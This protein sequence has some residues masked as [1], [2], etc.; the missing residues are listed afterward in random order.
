M[1][2][3]TIWTPKVLKEILQKQQYLFLAYLRVYQLPE[4][5]EILVNPNIQEKLGKFVSLP[6]SLTISEAKPVLNDRT[7]AQRKRQ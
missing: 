6:N 4:L 3:L 5:Q 1:S 2:K 7:F